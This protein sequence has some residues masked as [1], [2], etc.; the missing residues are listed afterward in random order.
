MGCLFG[1]LDRLRQN[2][3]DGSRNRIP[4]PIGLRASGRCL[5]ARL[6][7]TASHSTRS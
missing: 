7:T 6:S 3:W 4:L 1:T 5:L 2:P